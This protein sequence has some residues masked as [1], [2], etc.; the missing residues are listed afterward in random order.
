[1]I[2]GAIGRNGTMTEFFIGI[3][4]ETAG[5]IAAMV[6]TLALVLVA[7]WLAWLVLKRFR[8][9][10]FL[11]AAEKGRLPRLAVTDAVPVDSHRRLVLVRR[12]DVEHLI[13]IGGPSDIVVESGIARPGT[14]RAAI[15]PTQQA[16]PATAPR[17]AAAAARDALAEAER[18]RAVR[19]PEPQ[20]PMPAQNQAPV[21]A[22]ALAPAP[23]SPPA[24]L[25][26]QTLAA[27]PAAPAPRQAEPIA[28]APAQQAPAQ[29]AAP[30]RPAYTPAFPP[31]TANTAPSTHS[32]PAL[33]PL[34][35]P[36]APAQAEA[37]PTPSASR[38]LDDILAD[39]DRV[40][41]SRD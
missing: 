3:L 4:G 11:S 33:T 23:A 34:A 24:P 25:V 26:R 20:A 21:S 39:F 40:K 13:M 27:A 38:D 19:Q 15:Q 35:A 32:A 16:A 8:S 2:A 28:P 7:L 36:A 30:Q 12:D 18:G 29:P 5:P 31:L 1:M 17:P 10:L 22:P 14:Q 41:P 9:G 6:A 37:A